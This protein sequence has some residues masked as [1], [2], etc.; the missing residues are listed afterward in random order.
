[1]K[2]S[3]NSV[4]YIL[5]PVKG[6]PLSCVC[7]QCIVLL[8]KTCHGIVV[9]RGLGSCYDIS[10]IFCQQ[11]NRSL[12]CEI[13]KLME[14]FCDISCEKFQGAANKFGE[15]TTCHGS[16]TECP[17]HFGYIKLA[18]PVFNVGFFNS[19][20]NVLKCICKAILFP[21]YV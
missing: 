11:S 10:T 5:L 16:Y 14:D 12:P 21:P 4:F 6:M 19:I 13:N 9:I 15:C 20:V 18:L 17:G 3:H 8:I 7:V 2:C 1:M